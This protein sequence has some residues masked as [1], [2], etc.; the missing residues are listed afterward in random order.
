MIYK[1][2]THLT[3]YNSVL[4]EPFELRVPGGT[5]NEKLVRGRWNIFIIIFHHFEMIVPLIVFWCGLC[6]NAIIDS[7]WL[8][9]VLLGILKIVDLL[10]CWTWSSYQSIYSV[11]RLIFPFK[12]YFAFIY[13]FK[14]FFI[15]FIFVFYLFVFIF[16]FTLI[17]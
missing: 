5:F 2:W 8:H 6:K 16:L 11:V 12:F 15:F 14:L 3:L 1:R 9:S 13:F 4:I 7:D 17:F 10:H